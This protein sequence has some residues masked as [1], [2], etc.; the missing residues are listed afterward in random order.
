MVILLNNLC[1]THWAQKGIKIKLAERSARAAIETDNII[2][3][4]RMDGNELILYLASLTERLGRA[5]SGNIIDDP[6]TLL[7][8]AKEHGLRKGEQLI[9]MSE[10]LRILAESY[11]LQ[12]HNI[13]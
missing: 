10:D 2:K 13:K 1:H 8:R 7:D 9:V 4:Y 6:L 5:I 11:E 3:R 12:E